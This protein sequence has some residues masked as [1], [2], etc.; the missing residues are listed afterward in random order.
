MSKRRSIALGQCRPGG[1]PLGACLVDSLGSMDWVNDL[2]GL[3]FHA[4]DVKR[5]LDSY[6]LVEIDV[7]GSTAQVGG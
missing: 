5:Y 6:T 3:E 7:D 2:T 1:L 4:V